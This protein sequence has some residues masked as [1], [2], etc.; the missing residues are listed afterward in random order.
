MDNI[1]F[2]D[3]VYIY[4]VDFLGMG[5]LRFIYN[6]KFIKNFWDYYLV[7]L[8]F[9][10][11]T[12]L[13]L[14]NGVDFI[15]SNDK[16][17]ELS[18]L[19]KEF[20]LKKAGFKISKVE[21]KI[22]LESSGLKFI[23]KTNVELDV[24]MSNLNVI[25]ENFVQNQYG[26][27]NSDGKVVVDIGANIGDTAILFSKIKKAKKVIA[28]EP[29][30]YSYSIAKRNIN[31]NK[32]KN[33]I[34]LN[35]A[36][37]G[38]SGYLKVDST[39]QNTGSDIIRSFSSGKRIKVVTLKSVVDKYKINEGILKMD[40]EGCEYSIILN[41]S[42]ET[43]RKFKQIMLECHHGYLNIK[44]KLEE[45]GFKVETSRPVYSKH[46]N[47]VINICMAQLAS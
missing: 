16:L 29:Y 36:V 28:F 4:I 32:L 47:K 2:S 10:K 8:K 26:W 17:K 6:L 33:V 5:K 20:E 21:D 39:F 30:P 42:N 27:L 40:C 9:I 11:K 19:N 3:K 34:L 43:L 14:N 15:F 44:R 31:L 13:H 23:I 24:I 35:E 37:G 25:L 7:R 38:E 46:E 41:A 1:R 18:I 45:A 12:T 22:L